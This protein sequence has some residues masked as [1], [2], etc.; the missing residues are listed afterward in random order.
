MKRLWSGL[1]LVLAACKLFTDGGDEGPNLPGGPCLLTDF[2]LRDAE[3]GI[4]IGPELRGQFVVNRIQR[5]DSLA[6]WSGEASDGVIGRTSPLN[7]PLS[8]SPLQWAV[9]VPNG[10]FSGTMKVVGDSVRWS[11]DDD[12][13]SIAWMSFRAWHLEG[14]HLVADWGDLED[15]HWTLQARMVC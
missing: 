2:E 12:R 5:G 8:T 7:G 3:I 6:S 9:V 1:F 14:T 10:N 15:D 13:L 4:R 11:F